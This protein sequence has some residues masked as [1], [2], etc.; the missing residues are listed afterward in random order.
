M[1]LNHDDHVFA[2]QH[3]QRRLWRQRWIDDVQMT[4]DKLAQDMKNIQQAMPLSMVIR[5][6]IIQEVSKQAHVR[7]SIELVPLQ[8]ALMDLEARWAFVAKLKI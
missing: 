5:N 3:Y 2:Y 1:R 6:T 7:F 8:Y 4:R